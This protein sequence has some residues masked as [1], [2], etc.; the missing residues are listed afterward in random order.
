M[1]IDVLK[2]HPVLLLEEIL[3]EVFRQLS[4]SGLNRTL[5]SAARTC[6][7]WS[8]VALNI[9]WESTDM[10]T[11]LGVLSPV[12]KQ[13][14][15]LTKW[16]WGRFNIIALKVKKLEAVHQDIKATIG[17]QFLKRIIR[18]A[19]PSFFIPILP[20]IQELTWGIGAN[21]VDT[22]QAVPFMSA[23]LRRLT[24][25]TRLRP[26]DKQIFVDIPTR[27]PYITDLVFLDWSEQSYVDHMME[28]VEG[29]LTQ[30]PNLRSV[31][32][33]LPGGSLDATRPLTAL[34]KLM[35]LKQLKLEGH[36]KADEGRVIHWPSSP[37]APTFPSLHSLSLGWSQHSIPLLLQSVES[38]S[39]TSINLDHRDS[40]IADVAD[41]IRAAARQAQ[42]EC[43][44]IRGQASTFTIDPRFLA[45]VHYFS[46]LKTLDI[47]LLQPMGLTDANLESSLPKLPQLYSFSLITA[48][49]VLPTLTLHAYIIITR[50]CPEI[51]YLRLA[52]KASAAGH[53]A[54]AILH[55][56]SCLSVVDVHRSLIE[57]GDDATQE[58]AAFFIRLSVAKDLKVMHYAQQYGRDMAQRWGDVMRRVRALRGG[59]D[60]EARAGGS[61]EE[62]SRA[63]ESG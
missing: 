35:D 8:D 4:T 28:A 46:S 48:S 51:L 44:S 14:Y 47:R 29:M 54:R 34:S 24:I 11:L 26:N 41:V 37:S 3:E 42:L 36:G 39:L 27:S 60:A 17:A 25:K 61:S 20:R 12:I 56:H 1:D 38:S 13:Y 45:P 53:A 62:G 59:R 31:H 7:A 22:M 52:V 50:L 32:L 18:L 49:I 5:D 33:Q 21:G 58:V 43:L 30:L 19:A 16:E 55:A 2:C 63:G 40:G 9:L 10:T 15:Y 23:T 57:D 6:R